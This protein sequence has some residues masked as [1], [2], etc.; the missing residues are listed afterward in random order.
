MLDNHF[1]KAMNLAI[2]KCIDNYIV[3][4]IDI[5]VGEISGY[6]SLFMHHLLWNI[7]YVNTF[8]SDKETLFQNYFIKNYL[9]V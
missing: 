6:K 1:K 5:Y 8:F 2:G 3:Y 4:F 9:K 7:I